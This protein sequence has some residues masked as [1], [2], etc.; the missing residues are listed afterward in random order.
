MSSDLSK[1]YL[2]PWLFL[3]IERSP[4]RLHAYARRLLHQL[5][6]PSRSYSLEM[7]KA[8]TKWLVGA[9]VDARVPL[10]PEMYSLIAG[11]VK[12]KPR[13]STFREVHEKNEE[14]YW[15]AIQ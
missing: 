14:A 7:V 1:R 6:E 12:S 11:V 13:V 3:I 4:Q 10:V 9:Y 15:A 2:P 5:L 8:A